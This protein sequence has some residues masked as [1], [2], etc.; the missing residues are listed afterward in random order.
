VLAVPCGLL[1][2]LG[3]WPPVSPGAELIDPMADL[4]ACSAHS[5]AQAGAAGGREPSTRPGVDEQPN[6]DR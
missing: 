6:L 3:P 4:A 5:S 2:Y 1:F